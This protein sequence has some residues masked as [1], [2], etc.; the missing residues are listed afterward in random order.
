MKQNLLGLE[1]KANC[2]S[3]VM[4]TEH[5][6]DIGRFWSMSA[7]VSSG[8]L[9]P[10]DKWNVA[11][12]N[13]WLARQSLRLD[14][15]DTFRVHKIDGHKL[16]RLDRDTMLHWKVKQQDCTEI[17][18]AIV[19][20]KQEQMQRETQIVKRQ[21]D[22]QMPTPHWKS[23]NQQD[24]N[25]MTMPRRAD[26]GRK[27]NSLQ[28]ADR[29]KPTT[30]P[31]ANTSQLNRSKSAAQMPSIK[32]TPE[33]K[34]SA[35]L[36]PSRS[37]T[38]IRRSSTP[39]ATPSKTPKK[40]KH[41]WG[42][43]SSS[44]SIGEKVIPPPLSDP[45]YL[46]SIMSAI[47]ADDRVP[48]WKEDL[49]EKAKR[50][51][52]RQLGPAAKSNTLGSSPARHEAQSSPGP[53]LRS[54]LSS[55]AKQELIQACREREKKM[56]WYQDAIREHTHHKQLLSEKEHELSTIQRELQASFLGTEARST[57][58]SQVEANA[59]KRLDREKNK[60]TRLV[61]VAD[62]RAAEAGLNTNK[63]E[64]YINNL[65][66][67]RKDF[68][69]RVAKVNQRETTMAADMK[70]FAQAAHA[71]LD[72]KERFESKLRRIGFDYKNEL[73]EFRKSVLSLQREETWLDESIDSTE[74]KLDESTQD[75]VRHTYYDVRNRRNTDEHNDIRRGYLVNQR[76]LLE[77]ECAA[78]SKVL[79]SPLNPF[80]KESVNG[81]IHAFR[82]RAE[83]NRSLA[84]FAEEQSADFAE[85]EAELASLQN[86]A[87]SLE[88]FRHDELAASQARSERAARV[89]ASRAQL[90]SSVAAIEKLLQGICVPTQTI[91]EMLHEYGNVQPFFA[92][93]D[94]DD[95]RVAN[96][97]DAL[98]DID[99]GIKS[100][101]ERAFSLRPQAES[102]SGGGEEP[103]AL[104]SGR[105][106]SRGGIEVSPLSRFCRPVRLRDNPSVAEAMKE[107]ETVYQQTKRRGSVHEKT[108]YDSE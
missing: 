9:L 1:A 93:G 26:K 72:E 44:K 80:E 20:L 37:T 103:A 90:D 40:S 98:G 38:S 50:R 21:A 68:M 86:D 95:T 94:T 73:Q 35:K 102:A 8:L 23:E 7:D 63:L 57:G 83:N 74:K 91:R 43:N 59:D 53:V 41:A 66:T 30:G 2:R 33:T 17:L 99:V 16:Q 100:L 101:R 28:P 75:E 84:T 18:A 24:N 46:R 52:E 76:Q 61:Q 70:F 5:S 22:E 78:L 108:L 65:R 4:N 107:L 89:D 19:Q 29:T 15:S 67:H 97:V 42:N 77:Q 10:L 60:L 3:Q 39:D 54:N 56:Q 34:T 55:L 25:N 51:R 96:I 47:H 58:L 105:G 49:L 31:A 6:S 32:R 64:T 45:G 71:S 81:V 27:H 12:V 14:Y 87:I 48:L 92:L 106:D 62:S 69:R 88:K 82:T 79:E 36:T 85:M 13:A 11:H 104:Y